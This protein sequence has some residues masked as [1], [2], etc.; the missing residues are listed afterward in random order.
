M[1]NLIYQAV[2]YTE[3]CYL[4]PR[5]TNHQQAFQD[6]QKHHAQYPQHKVDIQITQSFTM[7]GKNVDLD[8]IAAFDPQ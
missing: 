4:G 3:K 5:T 6:E 2:C 8:T 7:T 1:P